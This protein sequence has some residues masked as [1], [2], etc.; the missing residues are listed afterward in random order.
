MNEKNKIEIFVVMH[1]IVDLNKMNLDKMY[2]RLLVGKK[3]SAE[4]NII[5]DSTGENI[6]EKNK[7]YCE[8]TGLYWI[9]KNVECE[10]VGLCHY[11]RFFKENNKYLTRNDILEILDKQQADIILPPKWY[12]IS[13]VN[14]M[15]KKEHI[16]SDLDICR[17]VIGEIYP[18]YLNSFDKIMEG[19]I[20]NNEIMNESKNKT[21]QI[22]KKRIS[23]EDII[24][25]INWSLI[26][27]NMKMIKNSS[28]INVQK[29]YKEQTGVEVSLTFIRNQKIKMFKESA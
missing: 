15:Y 3:S 6:S 23:T 14:E 18:E 9:W 13:T 11:R 24:D 17:E 7:F 12:T 19:G 26:T 5:L 29:L 1:K 8:L 4:E 2:K 25:Y 20:T 21:R 22:R 16:A 27:D 10:Y 28:L